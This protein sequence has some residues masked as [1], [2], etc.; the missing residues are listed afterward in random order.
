MK[1]L[2]ALFAVV[3]LFAAYCTPVSA[4]DADGKCKGKS[5]S[6]CCVNKAAAKNPAAP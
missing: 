2:S 6:A 1:K 4:C 5:S 3:A